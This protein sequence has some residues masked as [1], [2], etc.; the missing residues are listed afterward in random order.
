MELLKALG[1]VWAIWLLVSIVAQISRFGVVIRLGQFVF[2][3][4][5][6]PL[7]EHTRSGK[8]CVGKRFLSTYFTLS[9]LNLL[10]FWLC[11]QNFFP[12]AWR[13]PLE[14]AV[15]NLVIIVTGLSSLWQTASIMISSSN[16]DAHLAEHDPDADSW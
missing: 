8:R 7:L 5:Y 16:I 1:W 15:F 12:S 3:R 2:G 4:R 14:K 9:F 11:F 13:I 6:Q 10:L